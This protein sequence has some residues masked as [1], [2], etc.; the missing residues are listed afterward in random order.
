MNKN[1]F[2]KKIIC[3][4]TEYILNVS[5]NLLCFMQ[6]HNYAYACCILFQN[7]HILICLFPSCRFDL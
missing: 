2:P 3:Y 4:Y 1:I 5:N 6:T 7:S